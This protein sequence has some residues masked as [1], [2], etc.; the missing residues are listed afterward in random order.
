[1]APQVV[2]DASAIPNMTALYTVDHLS[3][4]QSRRDDPQGPLALVAG[5][6]VA[7]IGRKTRIKVR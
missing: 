4:L 6:V 1:M 2:A 3:S 5:E 7:A